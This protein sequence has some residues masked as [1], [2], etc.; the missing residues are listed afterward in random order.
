M[1]DIDDRCPN[2]AGI[3]ANK[4]CPEVK[5]EVLKV[6]TQALTGILFETGKDVIKASSFPILNNVV[7]VMND[8]PVYN[9]A[10]NGHTDNVG[11]DAMNLDL[12]DRRAAAVKKYLVD[13]G[14]NAARMTSKGFGE[15]MPVA[16]NGT[17]AERTKNRRVEF[18]VVF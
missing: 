1:A 3:A 16:D 15:T 7:K 17:A 5:E 14:I 6:F 4:G 18:K 13:K 10:I 11:D 8:N 9:L 2:E 12:S